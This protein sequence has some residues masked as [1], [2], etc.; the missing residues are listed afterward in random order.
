LFAPLVLSM[1]GQPAK[2]RQPALY[3][4]LETALVSK[5]CCQATIMIAFLRLKPKRQSIRPSKWTNL[6]IF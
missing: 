3:T 2:S 5:V 4:D 6:V 1:S